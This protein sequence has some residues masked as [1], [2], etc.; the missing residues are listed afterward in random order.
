MVGSSTRRTPVALPRAGR[1]AVVLGAGMSGLLAAA[2]LAAAYDHVTVVERDD[3]PTEATPRR[4]VPQGRH[5]HVLL[6]RGAQAIDEVLP[7]FLSELTRD[8]GVTVENLNRMHLDFAGHVLCRDDSESDATHMQSRPFLESHVLD[9]VRA[10]PN[11]TVLDG[12]DVEALRWDTSGSRVLGATVVPRSRPD[13][14]VD[15]IAELVVAALGRGARVS[16]WLGAHGYAEPHEEELRVDL[17][18]ASRLVRLDPALTGDLRGVVVSANP[19]RPTGLGALLQEHDTWVLSLEGF[20][21]HHPPTEPD[22]W[23]EMAAGLAPPGFAD[24]IRGAEVLTDISVHRFPANLW[25]RYDKLDRFPAGLLVT[26]DA[27]CSF[28]PVYGQGMTVAALEALALRA[29]LRTGTRDVAA[30]FFARASRHVRVAW[31]SAVGG[32]LSMPPE[33]VPGRRPLPV[34]A[35]NS[36]LDLYLEAAEHD[37]DMSWH[38]LKVTGFDEP[39]RALFTPHALRRIAAAHRPFVRRTHAGAAA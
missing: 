3:L 27:V 38:F 37:A 10:L 13:E 16:S 18:Y 28:N 7:G 20:A 15:L 30:R 22:A 35:V 11:V 25:R 23:L 21:G 1:E 8:G 12:H 29:T 31:Q 34:R 26:G 32:D 17:M 6:S 33:I 5:I 39:V 36:Y 14:R 4:G 9:R 19:D 24:A 2:V